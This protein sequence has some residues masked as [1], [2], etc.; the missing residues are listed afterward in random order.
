MS[1]DASP[2]RPPVRVAWS[3]C[4][5]DAVEVVYLP[6]LA[7]LL[8]NR[9]LWRDASPEA[10]REILGHVAGTGVPPGGQAWG[11]SVATPAA[12]LRRPLQAISLAAWEQLLPPE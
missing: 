6:R 7:R 2:A 11:W 5:P 4:L 3:D 10:R 12:E 1:Q 8:V 9:R